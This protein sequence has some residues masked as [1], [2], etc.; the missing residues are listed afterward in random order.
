[1]RSNRACDVLWRSRHM[2][3]AL[4]VDGNGELSGIENCVIRR[5]HVQFGTHEQFE[6]HQT[7]TVEV[8]VACRKDNRGNRL[9]EFMCQSSDESK[10]NEEI[11]CWDWFRDPTKI[12]LASKSTMNYC[13][14]PETLQEFTVYATQ[15]IINNL[16]D[17]LRQR[18]DK[19]QLAINIAGHHPI[20]PPHDLTENMNT[21][22]PKTQY[23]EFTDYGPARETEFWS[24][25][26][27]VQPVVKPVVQQPKS[28]LIPDINSNQ[29]LR[30][31]SGL[32]TLSTPLRLRSFAPPAANALS[33]IHFV[34][35]TPKEVDD[36]ERG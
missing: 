10:V 33:R 22:N 29:L 31:S 36:S 26:K 1:M 8:I 18:I 15:Q 9:K 14:G 2:A 3:L 21:E 34:R 12:Q 19:H 13:A 4:F 17:H 11:N 30:G 6:H 24:Q 23:F 5:M 25:I 35:K 7:K 20:H 27:T 32:K 28:Q 16:P